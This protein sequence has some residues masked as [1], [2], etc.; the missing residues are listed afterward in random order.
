[1]KGCNFARIGRVKG[2]RCKCPV[3]RSDHDLPYGAGELDDK[4]ISLLS[5]MM[6]LYKLTAKSF[7][8]KV[9]SERTT[10]ASEEARAGFRASQ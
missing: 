1:M 4:L 6:Q 8:R 2:L 3:A 10:V 9:E 7:V 5:T